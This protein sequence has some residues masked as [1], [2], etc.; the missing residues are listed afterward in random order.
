MKSGVPQGSV[1]GPLLF[2]IYVYDLSDDVSSNV[3]LFVGNTKL[4]SRVERQENSVSVL[5][6]R[7]TLLGYYAEYSLHRPGCC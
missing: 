3:I 1:L 5:I 4:Y 7:R 6:F 2:L